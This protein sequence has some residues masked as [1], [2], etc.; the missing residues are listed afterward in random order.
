MHS[1]VYTIMAAMAAG[2]VAESDGIRV[3][4]PH[5]LLVSAERG[6]GKENP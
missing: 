4:K 1:N 6:G 5:A 2:S 3:E